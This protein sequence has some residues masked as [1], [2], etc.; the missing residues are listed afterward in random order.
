MSNSNA[1]VSVANTISVPKSKNA[2]FE[3]KFAF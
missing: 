2:P 1:N 3:P